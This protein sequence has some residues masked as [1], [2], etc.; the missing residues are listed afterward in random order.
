MRY[1][2]LRRSQ[3][4]RIP[5]PK[6]RRSASVGRERR[7]VERFE[8]LLAELS[9][10]MARASADVVDREIELWLGKICEALDLDRSAIYERDTPGQP[11]RTTHTWLRA[12]FP[13]FP[14]RYDPEKLFQK[15]TKWVMEGNQFTFANPSEI[16]D[17]LADIRP[18]V[19]RY[20]PKASAVVPMWPV[21]ELS[22]QQVS[23]S[24]AL[25]GNGRVNCSIAWLSRCDSLHAR[26]SAS[27][28][29]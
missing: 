25:L 3:I 22:E 28:P 4:S 26:S 8:T 18:T 2:L 6:H 13:P 7:E 1:S 27:N 11:V 15:T 24:S 20:G 16:P 17:E 29:R 9:A 23:A 5:Q 10:A 19:K 12:N 21:A 14:R